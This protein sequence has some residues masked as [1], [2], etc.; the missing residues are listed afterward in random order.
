MHKTLSKITSLLV[1]VFG[2]KVAKTKTSF[3]KVLGK[4]LQNG[5]FYYS[6]NT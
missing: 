4:I 5:L 3:S 1:S 2:A 6:Q